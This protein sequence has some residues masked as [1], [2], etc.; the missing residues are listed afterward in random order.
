MTTETAGADDHA[1][2][3]TAG[4]DLAVHLM[5]AV[6]ADQEV[7]ETLGLADIAGAEVEIMTDTDHVIAAVG[8]IDPHHTLL[9]RIP[10]PRAVRDHVPNPEAPVPP[11]K[12]CKRLP[13]PPVRKSTAG[14]LPLAHV[15]APGRGPDESLEAVNASEYD[16]LLLYTVSCAAC[17]C[18][19]VY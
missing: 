1:V 7:P 13:Q 17:V 4:A 19:Y 16:V 2:A 12:T 5:I 8:T 18:V 9:P 11:Q 10:S 6:D 3:V 15:H 14:V